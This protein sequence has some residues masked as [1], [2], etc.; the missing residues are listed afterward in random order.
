MVL[1]TMSIACN[2]HVLHAHQKKDTVANVRGGKSSSIF[3]DL[4]T[5]GTDNASGIAVV[6]HLPAFAKAFFARDETVTFTDIETVCPTEEPTPVV[7]TETPTEVSVSVTETILETCTTE[8][9]PVP[10]TET[11]PIPVT[12]PPV[13]VTETSVSVPQSPVAVTETPVPITET[14]PVPVT[15]KPTQPVAETSPVETLPIPVPVPVT[16]TAPAPKLTTSVGTS[17]RVPTTLTTAIVSKPPF[18][19]GSYNST[20][21]T[22]VSVSTTHTRNSTETRVATHSSKSTGELIHPSST[23]APGTPNE[24]GIKGISFQVSAVGAFAWLLIELL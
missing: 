22:P 19:S 11:V 13:P 9:T 7:T 2:P 14:P 24:A 20:T 3:E 18:T 5:S 23:P 16:G 17:V 6:D 10:A 8:T 4:S 12:E 1:L 21:E 15:K